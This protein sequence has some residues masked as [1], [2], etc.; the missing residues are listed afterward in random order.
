MAKHKIR[1]I[2]KRD[3]SIIKHAARYRLTTKETLHRLFFDANAPNAVTKVV[4]RLCDENWLSKFPLLYPRQ[5]FV[6]GKRA[7]HS[8]GLPLARSL[9]MGPQSLPTDFAILAYAMSEKGVRRITTK[10]L[11]T[12]FPWYRA[13]WTFS[14]HLLRASKETSTL[15]I[16]RI[17]LGGPADHVARKCY[18]DVFTRHESKEFRD[19]I[20]EQRIRL[21]VITATTDKA[22][23]IQLALQG[24]AWPP[25]LGLHLSVIPDLLP[26]LPRCPDAT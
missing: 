16:V 19:A 11:V 24:H 15:E 22:S 12:H 3:L 23:A 9:P 17:D 13:E 4:N 21:V 6:P 5:Y 7:V 1:R 20:R 18:S 14:P 8:L 10:E 25:G 26:L 2:S